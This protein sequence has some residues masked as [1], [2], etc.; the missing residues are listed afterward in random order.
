MFAYSFF[1]SIA[2]AAGFFCTF[3]HNNNLIIKKKEKRKKNAQEIGSSRNHLSTI[4]YSRYC[5]MITVWSLYEKRSAT[6][7]AYTLT[8]PETIRIVSTG[9]SNIGLL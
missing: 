5:N 2:S 1:I 6:T 8:I 3:K 7:T 9:C 4:L